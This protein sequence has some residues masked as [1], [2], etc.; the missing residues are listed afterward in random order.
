MCILVH[1]IWLILICLVNTV[2]NYISTESLKY[3]PDDQTV[4]NLK[5]YKYNH[6]N[7]LNVPKCFDI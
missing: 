1:L 3:D 6:I 5:G 4:G 2:Y 7:S